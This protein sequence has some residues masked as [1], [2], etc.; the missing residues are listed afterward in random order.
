[1]DAD[2]LVVTL[3]EGDLGEH[4]REL[5]VR[6]L[7]A[8]LAQTRATTTTASGL[9]VW[10]SGS[11]TPTCDPERRGSPL[12][13]HCPPDSPE[14]RRRKVR[15]TARSATPHDVWLRTDASQLDNIPRTDHSAGRQRTRGRDLG[16][17]RRRP[18]G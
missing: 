4:I 10:P 17:T 16:D 14:A 8:D 13:A 5:F 2:K 1:M 6:L 11:R 18:Y 9:T 7:L 15:R 3:A 12:A